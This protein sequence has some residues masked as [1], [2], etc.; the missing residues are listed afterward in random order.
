MILISFAQLQ[1]LPVSFHQLKE[2][3]WLD[4]KN[5]P[6]VSALA[7]A[8]G[9]CLDQKGCQEAAKMV[10]IG[11]T[12]VHAKLEKKRLKKLEEIKSKYYSTR[13]SAMLFIQ[14]I[15]SQSAATAFKLIQIMSFSFNSATNGPEAGRGS[16]ERASETE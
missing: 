14:V 13:L 4:L 6:L 7:E 8:A 10:V 9:D 2:L 5:N 11:M 15:G 3:R 1:R 16:I 12:V